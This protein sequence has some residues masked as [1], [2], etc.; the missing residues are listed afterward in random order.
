MTPFC[1]CTVSQGS[2]VQV[3]GTVAEATLEAKRHPLKEQT[4][5]NQGEGRTLGGGRVSG[6]STPGLTLPLTCRSH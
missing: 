4:W 5:K 3:V 6:Q 1:L 2:S